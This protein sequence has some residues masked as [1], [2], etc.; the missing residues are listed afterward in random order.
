MYTCINI[1]R[2]IYAKR[3]AK[4][5]P[6]QFYGNVDRSFQSNFKENDRSDYSNFCCFYVWCQIDDHWMLNSW[7]LVSEIGSHSLHN[8]LAILFSRD[9]ECSH[10]NNL[11]HKLFCYFS[12]PALTDFFLGLVKLLLAIKTWIV[13]NHWT[14]RTPFVGNYTLSENQSQESLKNYIQLI[15]WMFCEATW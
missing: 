4:N 13:S 9:V 12:S 7:L 14:V 5:A 2:L 15:N 10:S 6:T 3:N 11:W 8:Q 1:L